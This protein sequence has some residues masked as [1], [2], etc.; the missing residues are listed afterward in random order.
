MAFAIAIQ[1]PGVGEGPTRVPP[2]QTPPADVQDAELRA[3]R[4]LR[5]EALLEATFT[6]RTP[7]GA[8]GNQ[9]A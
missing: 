6:D 3:L 2:P 1:Q 4:L 7:S 9:P 5:R 8:C